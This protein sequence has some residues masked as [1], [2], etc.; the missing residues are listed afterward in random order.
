PSQA[1][2]RAWHGKVAKIVASGADAAGGGLMAATPSGKLP[3]GEGAEIKAG[4]HLTTDGRTRARL[5]LDDGSTVVLDR[6]T[7]VTIEGSPR[8]ITVNEGAVLADVAHVDK[9]PWA[10]VKT[11]NGDV[12]VLG[13]KLAVT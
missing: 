8:T 5:W 13:T 9:A 2:T 12:R 7:E 6:A 1:A 4:M 3:L 11:P 10:M